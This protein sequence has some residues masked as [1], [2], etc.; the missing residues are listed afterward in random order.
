[1][2]IVCEVDFKHS[3]LM[4]PMTNQIKHGF[5]LLFKEGI[6]HYQL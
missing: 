6:G 5:P 1:M 4:Q 2:M 3:E